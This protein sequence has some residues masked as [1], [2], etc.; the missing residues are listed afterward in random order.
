VNVSRFDVL[1]LWFLEAPEFPRYVGKLRLLASKGV[2]L[3]YGTNW[4]D[5][6]FPLSEDLPLRSIEFKPRRRESAA[7]AVD[8]AGPDQ[9]G[10]LVIRALTGSVAPSVLDYLY[11]AG[12]ERFGA[13]GVST[14]ADTYRPRHTTPLPGVEHAKTLS[15]I[16]GKIREHEPLTTHER[17]AF[18]AGGSL[19]GAK[20]KTVVEIDGH[21]WVL[22]FFNNENV[23]LPLVEHATMTLAAKAGIAVAQTRPIRLAGEH[24]L[25]VRR[26]DR[27]GGRRIHCLSAGTALRA[28]TQ[29]EPDLSYLALAEL[30]DLKG[31][32]A[33]GQNRRDMA[34][35][36]RRMVF[37]ILVDNTDDHEKNHTLFVSY[38]EASDARKFAHV[39]RLAPAYDVV[40]TNS[41]QGRHEFGIG[42]EGTEGTLKNA[43]SLCA[44]FGLSP[45]DAGH[46]VAKVIEAL[47]GWRVHFAQCGV[48]TSD[49]EELAL[50]LDGNALR[51][52]RETFSTTG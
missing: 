2:S 3:Q 42:S 40:P 34:E 36:F 7:G 18:A 47:N 20:P 48:S 45:A 26:F 38:D 13:F 16:A 15:E 23:D 44:R 29:G 33:T 51:S 46:E 31:N 14:S 41:G 21:Q 49:I 28:A 6:G 8:D 12:H 24:A 50:C 39:I 4:L 30:L 17:E 11:L 1:H 32:R 52:Q 27:D 10:E 9:W 37:N 25:A 19:G 43:M 5:G 35:L 22:K